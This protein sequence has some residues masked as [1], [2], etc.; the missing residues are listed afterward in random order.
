MAPIASATPIT[1]QILTTIASL[2]FS[3]YEPSSVTFSND[4]KAYFINDID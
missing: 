3:I 4:A 2:P 1:M